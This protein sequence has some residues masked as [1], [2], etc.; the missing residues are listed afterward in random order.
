[1]DTYQRLWGELT[2]EEV[3]DFEDSI[4]LESGLRSYTSWASMPRRSSS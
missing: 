1:M 2:D 3:F 4:R